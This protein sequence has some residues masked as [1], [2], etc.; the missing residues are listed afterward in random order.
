MTWTRLTGLYVKKRLVIRL[1]FGDPADIRWVSG[2]TSGGDVTHYWFTPGQVFGA[3]WWARLS[4]RRQIACFAVVEALN[5]GD[6]G[7]RLP[8]I[9]PAVRVH[10]FL[11]ARPIGR[12]RR[13]VDDADALIRRIEFEGI[14]P[15]HV[16]TAYYRA[17]G[18]SLRVK[19]EPRRLDHESLL[20]FERSG[21]HAN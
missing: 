18:Q 20:R 5:I 9:T 8:A 11:N 10:A 1:R 14:E 16:P 15:A 6:A 3:L 7:Y 17:A 2:G 12:D 13:V 19:R 21:I 4:P